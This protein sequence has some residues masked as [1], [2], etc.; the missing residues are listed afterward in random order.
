MA[1]DLGTMIDAYTAS[2]REEM[3]AELMEWVRHPSVSRADLRTEGAPYG[4][5]VREM[6]TFALNRLSSFGFRTEDHGGY[7]GSAWYGSAEEE[8]GFYAHLDVVPEGPNW[9]FKPY[10]PVVKDGFVIG[11]G[12]DDNKAAAVLGL[13]I[14]RF[15]KE[16]GIRLNKSFRL[17]MGCAEET[18]M[19]DFKTY[20]QRGGKVPGFGIV[21]DAGFPVCYAQK[22]GWN[23]DI[24]VPKGKDILEFRAGNVRNAVPGDARMVLRANA[25]EVIKAFEGAEDITAEDL[26]GGRVQITAKGQG[27]HAAF[28]E[29]TDNAATKLAESAVSVLSGS[30]YDIRGLEFIAKTF[31]NPFGEGMGFRY[32][33]EMSGKLSSNAGVF[34]VENDRIRVLLDIRYPVSAD[35]HMMTEGFQALLKEN[36]VLLEKLQIEKPF[37][38]DKNDERVRKLQESYQEITGR[39][40][41]PYAMGGGTYSRVI[42]GAITFG[43][44]LH[45]DEKPEFLPKGHGGAHGPDE[46]LHIESWLRAYK[47]YLRSIIRLGQ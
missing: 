35:I 47:I 27:G 10:E 46:V 40:D 4:P 29:G 30:A 17:M 9:I 37:Y 38:I 6:L 33:D 20:L 36:G 26:G 11:R 45:H 44:G 42:P 22:G 19:D 16:N 8:I 25:D 3:V 31:R 21:A 43:P 24:L 41:E 7:C 1:A 28:P 18:G 23:A 34:S 32:E 15:L 39:E 2:H 5:D 14:M 12:A 13:Y